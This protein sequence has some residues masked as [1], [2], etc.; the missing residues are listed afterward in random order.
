VL[1]RRK[2]KK[3]K[4]KKGLTGGTHRKKKMGLKE[5]R[6]NSLVKLEAAQGPSSW[7]SHITSKCCNCVGVVVSTEGLC[8]CQNQI[9]DH[10]SMTVLWY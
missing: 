5:K 7:Y 3:N 8:Y 10:R 2:K 9:C 4:K 6:T 1:A